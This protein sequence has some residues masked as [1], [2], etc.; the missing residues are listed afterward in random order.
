MTWDSNSTNTDVTISEQQANETV[1]IL[2]MKQLVIKNVS[3]IL[4]YIFCISSTV[5]ENRDTVNTPNE[6]RDDILLHGSD[7]IDQ[8]NFAAANSNPIDIRKIILPRKNIIKGR[9]KGSGRT[10]V[11]TKKKNR[12]NADTI[13]K[14]SASSSIRVTRSSSK[15]S[16]SDIPIKRMRL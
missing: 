5:D 11:G 7:R 9:P 8:S 12:R 14:Q 6:I 15:I 16:P 3:V 1:P 4:L 10:V 13:A 2:S